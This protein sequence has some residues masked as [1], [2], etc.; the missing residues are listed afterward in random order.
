[1]DSFKIQAKTERDSYGQATEAA[2][3]AAGTARFKRTQDDD[4]N[5]NV[6]PRWEEICDGVAGFRFVTMLP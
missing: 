5:D 3:Y 4:D 6:V 2:A 1:M